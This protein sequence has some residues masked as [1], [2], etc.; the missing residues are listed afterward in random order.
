MGSRIT[1][2]GV[3]RCVHSAWGGDPRRAGRCCWLLKLQSSNSSSEAQ[4]HARVSGCGFSTR[5][6]PHACTNPTCMHRPNPTPTPQPQHPSQPPQTNTSLNNNNTPSLNNNTPS[7]N[8]TTITPQLLI[9]SEGIDA[10]NQTAQDGIQLLS[11]AVLLASTFV[12]NQMGPIDEA[13]IDR[14]GLVTEVR[15]WGVRGWGWGWG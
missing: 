9:D 7:L 10:Y 4:Q 13:A 6:C 2:C 3:G 12:F 11:M 1:W 8:T 14:L 15:G 5:S